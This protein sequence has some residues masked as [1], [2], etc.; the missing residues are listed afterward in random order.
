MI[1]DHSFR[2]ERTCLYPVR[3]SRDLDDFALCGMPES[4][5]KE[6]AD[7]GARDQQNAGTPAVPPPHWFFGVRRCAGCGLGWNHIAHYF[8]PDRVRLVGFR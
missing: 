1:S 5:H 7:L 3:T 6:S 2:G 4:R 8:A